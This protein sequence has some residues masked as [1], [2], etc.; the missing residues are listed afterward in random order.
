MKHVPHE[1]DLVIFVTRSHRLFSSLKT[2]SLVIHTDTASTQSGR[3]SLSSLRLSS[4]NPYMSSVIST[5]L[6]NRLFAATAAA[7]VS[8]CRALSSLRVLP[9]SSTFRLL[10]TTPSSLRRPRPFSATAT[11]HIIMTAIQDIE[12]LHQEA[13][14]QGKKSYI[15][16]A[17]GFTVFTELLQLKRGTC[18]GNKCRHCPYG[19]DQVPGAPPR[20]AKLTSG[21]HDTAQAMVTAIMDS[22]KDA[23]GQVL[24]REQKKEKKNVPYTRT[25]D[26]GTSQ[27][28]TGERRSKDDL[29][30]DALGTV[31]ELCSFAGVVHAHLNPDCEY[32]DL[33]EW[34]LDIMSR[35]FDVGSHVA[36]PK[37]IKD[38][39]DD[40]EEGSSSF[41]HDGVGGGMDP[42]HIEQLEEWI[43]A[44]T[45]DMPELTSFILPTGAIAAAHLHVA[46][47]VCR[48]AERR[49][50]PL[51]KLGTCDPNA[52]KYVNRLSDFFF[53]A[54]RWVNFCEGKEEIQYQRDLSKNQRQRVSRTLR[55][56]K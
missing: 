42:L 4:Q 2:S 21:D 15:D 35:L 49:M 48:R 25:G 55:D 47:T 1:T 50:V 8:P 20:E 29:N 38:D 32:G 14:G 31:D 27:L 51:V 39:S 30:F 44:M 13:L 46:R 3:Q 43:I 17:T 28:L 10:S 5:H 54:A 56:K 12:D 18:C 33:N 19:W 41:D 34:M 9:V 22:A 52:M 36:K 45:D 26:S 11:P 16:P 7:V 6:R 23:N 53:T 40:D 24:T 37:K